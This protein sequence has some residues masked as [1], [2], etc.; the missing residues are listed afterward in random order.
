MQRYRAQS[1]ALGRFHG[2]LRGPKF[3]VQELSRLL[4]ERSDLRRSHEHDS[5]EVHHELG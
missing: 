3:G 4:R 1:A 5:Q 2:G